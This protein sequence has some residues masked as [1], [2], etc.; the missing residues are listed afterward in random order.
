MTEYD[1]YTPIDFPKV[2]KLA[3]KLADTIE[4]HLK[5]LIDILL[6]YES[7]EVAQ[8]EIARTLDLLRNLGENKKYF[9]IRV[10]AVTSF[11]PRNQPLYALTCF[12]IVP[13]LMASEVHFRIPHSMRYFFPK[14]LKL[15]G[16]SRLFP[17]VF[18]SSKS[19]IEFLTNRSAL[20]I[21]PKT[22]ES[23]LVTDV[24]IF[25][26]IPAHANQ[27]R[28]V[29]DR[30]TLFI[31]NGAGHNPVVV[32]KDAN[33]S[34]AVEA[35]ITLQFYNQ[36]QDCAAPN[37]I[38][39][40]KDVI[41]SFLASLRDRI[42]TIKVGHYQDKSCQIGPISEPKDLVRIQDFLIEHREWLDPSTPGIIRASDAV[43]EPTI[44]SKPLAEGGNFSEI[45][46][47]VIFVQEY[48]SDTELKYYFEDK[49]Y[50]RNAMYITLYGTSKYIES[51]ID[52]PIEG[53]VLH[54]RSSLIHN[55]HL[56]APG[57]ER[58]TQ[59]YGGYGYG[60]SSISINDKIITKPTLPQRDIYEW[61]V[62][63][64]IVN[65]ET[66]IYRKEFQGFKK[67]QRKDV[68]KLLKLRPSKL[69]EQDQTTKLSSGYLDLNSIKIDGL[70]YI[71]L[72]E[73]NMYHLLKDKNGEYIAKL[74]PADL[75]LIRA[76][77]RL[78]HNKNITSLNE[79][80]SL[81]Y[82]IAKEP[83]ASKTSNMTR[84]HHFFQHIYQL[85]LGNKI[86]PRLAPFLWYVEKKEVY[87]LLDV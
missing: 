81:L 12:V 25:T 50:A 64:I 21:N 33:I 40:H 69:N 57:I 58:G 72:D 13:S 31:S 15:L 17:N 59:P 68:E 38:L 49:H 23:R 34:K 47:P 79:F 27:L 82:S 62:K 66:E 51:L 30:R 32:S 83:D 3:K 67:I 86:G 52:R 71:K 2:E 26:G 37:A 41:Q 56:H 76:L 85:L 36:G 42:G 75:K 55:T 43:V 73:S 5:D 14:L 48:K 8:D 84:Q 63:P 11:L 4:N 22:K 46:A 16:I 61:V 18:V 28:L 39:V 65:K 20:Y 77:N 87:K 53:K 80:S 10:S 35:V 45:F 29:F 19:R 78:L 74:E 6:K 60:A 70:R 24:V 44:I 1:P 9:H 7:Y 54:D